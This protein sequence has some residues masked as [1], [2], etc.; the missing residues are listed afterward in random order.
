ME[1][2]E[3]NVL[4]IKPE[5]APELRLWF[6]FLRESAPQIPGDV[7][8]IGVYRGASLLAAAILL[9]ELD[10]GKEIW[11]FDSFSGFPRIDW[12]DEQHAFEA[13]LLE[14]QI[15]Q[16]HWE[17]IV[18]NRELLEVVGR[19]TDP[20]AS[21][22]S[23]DFSLTSR[24]L[25]DSVVECLE[26]RNV[27]LIEGPFDQTL[28]AGQ[29]YPG[30]DQISAAIVD[31]DLYAGYRLALP[32]IWRRLS[33]GGLIWLDE[34]YSLKFPGPRRAVDE[35]CA[36]RNIRPTCLSQEDGWERWGLFME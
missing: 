16:A 17:R 6:R 2:W 13:L 28:S 24:E 30:L 27:N 33:P 11:G 29:D 10:S 21:S 32:W 36:E 8:E 18:R 35:F 19:S 5:D 26:V 9:D 25:I 3:R 22:T 23:G 14:G 20:R 34:Y 15:T 31:C 12:Q 4:G 1:R 7:V